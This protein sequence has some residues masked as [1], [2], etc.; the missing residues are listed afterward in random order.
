MTGTYAI[1][2]KKKKSQ[3]EDPI[4]TPKRMPLEA[5]L[6]RLFVQ[7]ARKLELTA[8]PGTEA[9]ADYVRRFYEDAALRAK[10]PS[11]EELD[12]LFPIVTRSMDPQAW[13]SV[14]GAWAGAKGL[15]SLALG[16]GR[17]GRGTTPDSLVVGG[18][19]LTSWDLWKALRFAL[20][21]DPSIRGWLHERCKAAPLSVADAIP[22]ALLFDDCAWGNALA[23]R[24]L[25]EPMD[26]AGSWVTSRIFGVIDD[27]VRFSKLIAWFDTQMQW[28]GANAVL[29][30]AVGRIPAEV[31][32]K[33]L[34]ALLDRGL[35]EKW[36]SSNVEPYAKALAHVKGPEVAR[37]LAAWIGE[38]SVAK[39]ADD[40]FR[41]HP[42]LA[43]AALGPVAKGKGKAARIA[44]ALL[45]SLDRA[46][47]T[48][49]ED[50]DA[51]KPAKATKANAKT[52]DDA[53]KP[54]KAKKAAS[55]KDDDARAKTSMK[56]SEVTPAPAS[57]ASARV[58]ALL[59][60]P[61]WAAKAR[62][63]RP[64]RTLTPIVEDER[65]PIEKKPWAQPPSADRTPERDRAFLDGLAPG[66][67]YEGVIFHLTDEVAF[68]SIA[69]RARAGYWSLD[70]FLLWLGE[71][72]VPHVIRFIALDVAG[73]HPMLARAVSPRLALPVAKVALQRSGGAER[74][75]SVAWLRKN[76]DAAAL[77]LIPALLGEDDAEADVAERALRLVVR[78]GHR[79]VID[80]AASRY[81]ADAATDVAAILDCSPYERVPLKMPT[82]AKWATPERLGRLELAGGGAL[83]DAQTA[84]L[85]QMLQISEIG[86]PY[87]GAADAMA[88]L[89]EASKE[90]FAKALFDEYLLAGSP[91]SHEWVIGALALLAPRAAIGWLKGHMRAWAADGK[92]SLLHH[93]LEVLAA[94]GTDEALLVVFDA[95]QR[96]RYDDTRDKVRGI[97]EGVA[98]ERGISYEVLEDLLVPELGLENGAVSLDLGGR[99]L[100]VRLGDHLEAVL[101]D[102]EGKTLSAFPK[103]TKKDDDEAYEAAKKRYSE[104]VEA[105]EAV[106]KTQVLRFERALRMQRSWSVAELRAHV[107]PQPL[108][109]HLARRL[110]WQVLGT[111]QLFRVAE[112]LT[113]A[114]V[115][116]EP[117]PF[118]PDDAR[119]VIAHPLRAPG[120]AGFRTWIEDYRVIQPFPQVGRETFALTDAE[121]A[122]SA[123]T[124]A[125]GREV[126]Y[127]P[128]LALTLGMGWKPVP[129]GENGIDAI[130]CVVPGE[131]G[132]LVARLALQPGLLF[133]AAKGRPAQT[134]G[135]LTLTTEDGTAA[136]FGSIEPLAASELLRD[137]LSLG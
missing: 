101:T 30:R 38:K 43:D 58:L 123:F 4:E 53:P 60:A 94:I 19:P 76:P 115:K 71:R 93:A 102:E 81:G 72:V 104:L 78:A 82:K 35:A 85:V 68:E 69:T 134:L 75:A 63:S 106:G 132:P 90:R 131:G 21:L 124:R 48:A 11:A 80:A 67:V 20:A 125:E 13:L 15:A 51:P 12:A 73:C 52:S 120:L 109:R 56:T 111:G 99:T 126:A 50:D 26:R 1:D 3:G 17:Y 28:L 97:L 29:G 66:Q 136:R 24:L 61:P 96:S 59:D 49:T 86:E 10:T 41:A 129:P 130:T 127:L 128:V 107:L 39:I 65:C 118:P 100:A 91:P 103:K 62:P 22:C 133:G 87:Q 110:V 23:D 46:A 33:E 74:A 57:D 42:D 116:D 105:S 44:K 55:K 92:V 83:S 34:V 54:A 122:A 77:G 119:V 113:L 45:A 137:V 31:L 98:A 70:R 108:V 6:D 14:F 18:S 5:A 7:H 25:A 84:N 2:A 117:M 135:A 121:K 95:G 64:R 114:D 79:D 40:Y 89:T 27:P 88:I 112:D 47:P 9:V 36:K 16:E 37:V 32:E 8:G